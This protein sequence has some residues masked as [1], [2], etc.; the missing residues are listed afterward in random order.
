MLVGFHHTSVGYRWLEIY[1]GVQFSLILQVLEIVVLG[2]LYEKGVGFHQWRLQPHSIL[3][4][5]LQ[6]V[7]SWS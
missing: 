4:F 6:C 2:Q 3:L 5:N 7:H 1:Y